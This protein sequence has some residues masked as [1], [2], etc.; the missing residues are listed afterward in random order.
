M[1]LKYNITK[2]GNGGLW[3]DLKPVDMEDQIR[4]AKENGVTNFS[5]TFHPIDNIEAFPDFDGIAVTG[6]FIGSLA[7]IKSNQ[8]LNSLGDLRLLKMN[9]EEPVSALDFSKLAGIENLE[10]TYNNK[11]KGLSSLVN[12]KELRLFNYKPA[13]KDLTEFKDYG[14]IRK[15]K[16]MQPTLSSLDGIHDLPQLTEL[17]VFKPKGFISFFNKYAKHSLPAL[18]TLELSFCK[19]LDFTSIPLIENLT[20]LRLNDNG[21]NIASLDFI[22]NCFPNLRS[23]IFTGSES[24]DG[25]MDTLVKHP[26]IER[27]TIDHKKHY[28]L[29]EKEI[30]ALLFEKRN[31]I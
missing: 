4:F 3:M 29:K 1:S 10:I 28:T 8:S 30:N 15:M 2:S 22:N 16:L 11:V 13:S 17:E 18:K 27:V 14:M 5:C 19:E 23:L 21:N 9:F 12:L 20:E 26:A 7:G 25:N 6:L 24:K 31:K